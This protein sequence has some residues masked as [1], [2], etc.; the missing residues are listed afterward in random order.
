MAKDRSPKSPR[1]TLKSSVEAA[2]KLFAGAKRAPIS[3]EAAAKTMGYAG[4]TGV[5]ATILA[6]LGG[7]GLIQKRGADISVSD[8]A[9]SILHPT[10][11]EQRKAALKQAALLPTLFSQLAEHYL[12]VDSNV[13]TSKLVQMGFSPDS[14]KVTAKVFLSNAAYAELSGGSDSGLEENEETEDYQVEG[15]IE[16]PPTISPPNARPAPSM[17]TFAA[18][19]KNVLATYKIPLGANEAELVFTG[20]SLEPEDFDALIDYVEIFKKQ[21]Q[22][23]KP[24]VSARETPGSVK[25]LEAPNDVSFE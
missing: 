6:S 20:E 24:A 11:P 16:M 21:F 1:N 7:Y 25:N 12:E 23:K 10:G 18:P 8:L 13:L 5:S 14:A 9:I 19:S 4:I 17:P 3:R 2:G 22:R 15:G